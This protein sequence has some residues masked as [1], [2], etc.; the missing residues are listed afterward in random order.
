MTK[1][2]LNASNL[3]EAPGV[4][5]FRDK[6]DNILYIGKATNLKDRTKSY[7]SKDLTETRGLKIVN[8]VLAA[9]NVTYKVT[10]SVLE[11]LLLESQLIKKH[12]PIFNSKEKD[13]K[14]YV[15]VVITKE[16]FPR[17]LTMRVRDYEKRFVSQKTNSLEKVDKVYGPYTSMNQMREAMRIIRKLFPY[18]D[19]C[20]V[21]D[22]KKN[23]KPC[24]NAQIKLCPGSCA[25]LITKEEY[26]KNIK[27]LKDLFEGNFSK[28]KRD[29]EKEMN[30]EAK[31]E[32]FEK[33]AKIRNTIWSLSHI[34]DISLI[35]DEDLLDFKNKN[36]RIEAYDV[37]HIS[38]TSRVGAMSVVVNGVKEVSE[39]R[40]FK[41]EENT[42]DDYA[43][44]AEI[45]RRRFAHSDWEFPDLIVFDGGVGQKNIGDK[46]LANMN[47]SIET[48]AVTKD[49]RHKAKEIIGNTL[50]TSN[51]KL[52]K[53]IILANSEVHRFAI[54]YHKKLRDVIK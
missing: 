40:K 13:D 50:T 12:Q 32:N 46:V 16:D 21:Y 53:A 23:T 37:A 52:K 14:S 41:L 43:G 7:F 9:H 42:N 48:C 10:E 39:Y 30:K 34:K 5:F 18:R 28:I 51:A 54:G 38:G 2:E 44:L 29:L 33:A 17:V 25:G 27:H 3:P 47:I 15:C 49:E 31:N 19:R 24:F 45:I 1:S 26:K 22:G 8:M 20:E 4:Y 11:A 35:K 6:Q 36:Y